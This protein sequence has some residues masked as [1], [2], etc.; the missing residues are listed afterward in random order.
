ME[1]RAGTFPSLKDPSR[2]PEWPRP[3]TALLSPT[4]PPLRALVAPALLSLHI[5][6][7]F[8]ECSGNA[9]LW[10]ASFGNWYSPLSIVLGD[11]HPHGRTSPLLTSVSAWP[12]WWAGAMA[13]Q[14][15]LVHPAGY[16]AVPRL[17]LLQRMLLETSRPLDAGAFPGRLSLPNTIISAPGVQVPGPT[18]ASCLVSGRSCPLVSQCNW[19]SWHSCQLHGP[20][21]SPL[22]CPAP[23]I[24]TCIVS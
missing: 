3:L 20:P 8:L 13:G 24:A 9:V 11:L 14:V 6:L 12:P 4:P 1:S 23:S 7:S 22:P 5:H 19:A 15:G 18:V 16:V 10:W 17:G 2:C 21:A